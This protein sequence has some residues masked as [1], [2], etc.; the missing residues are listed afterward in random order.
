MLH[1]LA[2]TTW[3]PW[4]PISRSVS[5][6]TSFPQVA[7][8]PVSR[9]KHFLKPRKNSA[10]YHPN[11]TWGRGEKKRNGSSSFFSPWFFLGEK[12][13]LSFRQLRRRRRQRTQTTLL[14]LLSCFPYIFSNSS[15]L[16]PSRRDGSQI[17]IFA[18]LA[19][20]L[21]RSCWVEGGG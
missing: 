20:Y 15:P 7:M 2:S 6:H 12:E 13:N 17:Y 1:F 3:Q 21:L 5:K 9:K 8:H 18:E 16:P 14:L 19:P 11:F 10:L 4:P